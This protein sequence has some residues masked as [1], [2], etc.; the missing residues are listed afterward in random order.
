MD[1][2]RNFQEY[3]TGGLDQQQWNNRQSVC[4]KATF[5]GWTSTIW[6]NLIS[7]IIHSNHDSTM[8]AMKW[9]HLNSAD[10]RCCFLF[11]F[12]LFFFFVFFPFFF[13][14]FFFLLLSPFTFF[15]VLFLSIVVLISSIAHIGRLHYQGHGGSHSSS[16]TGVLGVSRKTDRK[17]FACMHGAGGW[18]RG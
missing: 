13:F 4:Q 9:T 5:G 8:S 17:E 1:R 16:V 12:L 3:A 6:T 2:M 7:W 11:L 15:L 10:A 14:F 18:E